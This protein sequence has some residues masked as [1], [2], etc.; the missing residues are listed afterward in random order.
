M[1]TL[2]HPESDL[3]LSVLTLAADILRLFS[4]ATRE[5]MV[6]DLLEQFLKRDARRTPDQFFNA[7]TMLY[8]VDLIDQDD[9]RLRVRH[10]D[11]APRRPRQLRL[12]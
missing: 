6:D 4:R 11:P 9:Y 1:G 12:V 5:Q 10:L 3:S 2:V 7:L 8:M